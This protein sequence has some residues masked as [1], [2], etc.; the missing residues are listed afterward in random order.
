MSDDPRYA[1]DMS[2]LTPEERS[3]IEGVMQKQQLEES[4]EIRFLKEKQLEVI[5]LENQIKHKA[6]IQ[7]KAGVELESTCQVCLKTKFADGVGHLCN[8]CRYTTIFAAQLFLQINFIYQM[9]LKF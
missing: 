4:K 6:E 3:I 8:Y 7:K 9:Q 1:M 2:H 5:N